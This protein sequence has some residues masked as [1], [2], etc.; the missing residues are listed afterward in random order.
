MKVLEVGGGEK[1]AYCRRYNPDY[2]NMDIRPITGWVDIVADLD[3]PFPLPDNDFDLIYSRYCVEHVNWRV[4]PQFINEL[5]RVLKPGGSIQ[6]IVPNLR[7]QCEILASKKDWT[8]ETDVCMIFG[9]LNYGENSHKS[10]CSPELYQKL[11]TEAGFRS[12]AWNPLPYWRGDMI[13]E[14]MK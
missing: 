6:V 5:Y 10:S 13:I 9:D 2:T 8:L 14:A 3:K 11:F 4:L 1:P 12:F 7:A